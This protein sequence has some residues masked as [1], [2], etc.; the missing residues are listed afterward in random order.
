MKIG[1]AT[2]QEQRERALA[3]AAGTRT[4]GPDEPTAWFP[5]ISA[6]ASVFSDENMA[7][8]KTIRK[9]HPESIDALAEAVGKHTQDVSRSLRAMEP[10]GV[11]KLLKKGRVVTPVATSEHVTVELI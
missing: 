5:N 1:I 8:L 2:V 4:R 7:L 11:V 6:I 10:Y 3:I 9:T